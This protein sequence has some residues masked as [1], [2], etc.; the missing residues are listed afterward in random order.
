L[1]A[2]LYYQKSSSGSAYV[3]SNLTLIADAGQFKSILEKSNSRLLVIDLYADWCAPCKKME[4]YLKEIAT[5][6][7][8]KVHL[9]RINVDENQQLAMELGIDAIPVLRVYKKNALSWNNMGYVDKEEVLKQ[10]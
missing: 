10:L 5:D 1:F 6:M 2:G 8:D 7:S 9:V 4:P 3:S